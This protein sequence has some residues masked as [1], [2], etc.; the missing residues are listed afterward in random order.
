MGHEK[1]STFR[2]GIVLS[3]PTCNTTPEIYYSSAC[4]G[5]NICRGTNQK[6]TQKQI[7]LVVI[8]LHKICSRYTGHEHRT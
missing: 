8:D 4:V 6:K 2:G 1:T 7:K 3:Y 5:S